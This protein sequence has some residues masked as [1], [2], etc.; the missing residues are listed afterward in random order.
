MSDGSFWRKVPSNMPL[1]NGRNV[2]KAAS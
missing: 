1:E 2:P